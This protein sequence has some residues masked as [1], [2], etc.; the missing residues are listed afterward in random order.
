EVNVYSGTCSVLTCEG[1]DDDSGSGF[2]ARFSINTVAGTNYYMYVHSAF[3]NET[4]NFC[5][6][7]T[8]PCPP[9]SIICPPTQELS[10]D[11]DCNATIPDYSG[12]ATLGINCGIFSITQVP[13]TGSQTSDVGNIVGS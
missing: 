13:A 5:F 8:S 2:D 1:G 9:P 7:A 3:T 6:T 10:L 11:T 4:S 12:L